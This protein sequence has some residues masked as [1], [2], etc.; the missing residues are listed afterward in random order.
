MTILTKPSSGSKLDPKGANPENV[1]IGAI[2]E[3]VR[4]IFYF[5]LF[6]VF[7][8]SIVNKLQRNLIVRFLMNFNW[9][10]N[11]GPCVFAEYLCVLQKTKN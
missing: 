3:Q 7:A 1:E 11:Y 8:F 5:F 4:G 2:T 6:I 10:P 9:G